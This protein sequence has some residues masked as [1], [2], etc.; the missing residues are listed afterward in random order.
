M[1]KFLLNMIIWPLGAFMFYLVAGIII[2]LP[3]QFA[4][5]VTGI[6]FRLLGPLTHYHRRAVFN[7]RYAMPELSDIQQKQITR[8]MWDNIGRNMGEYFH[9]KKLIFSD[10][11]TVEGE[12]HLEEFKEKGGFIIGAHI[13]NWEIA[14][15]ALIR[16]NM[17]VNSVYRPINNPLISVMLT[18]RSAIYNNIYQK[19]AEAARG[20]TKSIKNKEVFA[21]LVDQKLRE[22]ETLDFFGQETSTP[23]SYLRLAKRHHLPILMSRI[24]RRDN[25]HFHM[26]ITKVNLPDYNLED[27]EFITQAGSHIN[28]IIEDW[29]R[30]YPEQWLWP[31]RRWPASKGEE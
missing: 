22:G 23:T 6:L 10:R 26:E 13:G 7:I 27:E 2:L 21:L 20:M 29:I 18:R 8:K 12:E 4:S 9:A 1:K 24:I 28:T 16:A 25:C 3:V 31:H 19:G 15:T 17:S 30:E 5:H 14:V 11:V